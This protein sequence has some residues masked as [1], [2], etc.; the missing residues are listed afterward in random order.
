[1]NLKSKD[2]MIVPES[3]LLH[4]FSFSP[5][6][7]FYHYCKTVLNYDIVTI[8]NVMGEYYFQHIQDKRQRENYMILDYFIYH[9]H[10]L[11]LDNNPQ[12]EYYLKENYWANEL[13][14]KNPNDES[15]SSSLRNIMRLSYFVDCLRQLERYQRQIS[16]D[17]T[18][19][20][21]IGISYRYFI[22]SIHNESESQVKMLKNYI[23]HKL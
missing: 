14:M 13:C 16:K 12:F 5:S 4:I 19:Q 6:F 1:M 10:L 15:I 20:T 21:N 17:K 11:I 23:K 22:D 9:K 7:V 8:L 2:K 3:L 18:E